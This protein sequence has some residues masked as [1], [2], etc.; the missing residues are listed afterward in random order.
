MSLLIVLKDIT[1]TKIIV[2][3]ML[4]IKHLLE[5]DVIVSQLTFS[6]KFLVIG[7]II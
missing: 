5:I 7:N 4:I 2:V 3:K 6:I 1:N